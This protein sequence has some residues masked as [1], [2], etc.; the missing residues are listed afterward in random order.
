MKKVLTVAEMAL[1][2]LLRRRTVLLILLL[3]PL[4]FYLSR[5]G[6]HLGQ[7]IRFVCLGLGWA[8]STAALFA[9]SASRAMEPRLRL[10]G[11]RSHHLYLGRLSALWTVGLVLSAPYFV[12]ILVDQ[13]DVRYGSVGLIMLLTLAVS[14][15]FGL[16]LSSVLP[17]EL[18][19]TLV[20]L[21]V[22]GL[23][24]MAD[25]SSLIARLLPFWSSR[26]IG[27]YAIEHTDSGYLTRGIA[28]GVIS[29]AVLLAAVAVASGFRLRR[30]S[31]LKFG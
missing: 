4:V 2:E 28:H 13:H 22:V 31:H 3:L 18:E 21:V 20:L 23:Q 9:G 10:S 6:D 5:R 30:R 19:G 1:R 25:P 12:L 26:E 7:S 14:A 11:Y 27:T 16:A 17:R 24:M 8:L 15:P 29:M